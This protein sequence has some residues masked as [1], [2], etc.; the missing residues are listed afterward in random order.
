MSY[1]LIALQRI[2]GTFNADTLGYVENLLTWGGT[3]FISSRLSVSIPPTNLIA[4]Y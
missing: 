4:L 3:H 2:I 1:D